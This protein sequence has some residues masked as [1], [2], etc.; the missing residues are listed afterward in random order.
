MDGERM[1]RILPPR[2]RGAAESTSNRPGGWGG[3]PER[4]RTEASEPTKA[5]LVPTGALWH[6][7]PHLRCEQRLTVVQA[8]MM[9]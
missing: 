6:E 4:I 8:R 2:E 1:N 3:P 9:A 5:I 7:V